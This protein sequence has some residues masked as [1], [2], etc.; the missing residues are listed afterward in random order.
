MSLTHSAGVFVGILDPNNPE[1]E[2]SADE[3]DA[4]KPTGDLTFADDKVGRKTFTCQPARKSR[5]PRER[6][7]DGTY[8]VYSSVRAHAGDLFAGTSKRFVEWQR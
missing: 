5:G 7:P 4:D 3:R 8:L 1:P 2:E 6:C